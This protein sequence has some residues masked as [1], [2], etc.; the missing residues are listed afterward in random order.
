M[1]ML[2]NF[3]SAAA[4]LTLSISIASASVVTF[5]VQDASGTNRQMAWMQDGLGYFYGLSGI[6]GINGD[7]QADVNASNQLLVYPA[8]KSNLWAAGMSNNGLVQSG[9]TLLSSQNETGL[10]GL[11]SAGLVYSTV[12]GTSG[13][14]NNASGASGT[15]QAQMGDVVFTAGSTTSAMSAGANIAGWFIKSSDG[16]STFEYTNS[17]ATAPARAPDF[18]IPFNATAELANQQNWSQGVHAVRIPAYPFHV[19]IQNNTGVA[20]PTAISAP[21]NTLRLVSP[22]AAY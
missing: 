13:V 20:L 19:L 11:A 2:R 15:A 3:F 8:I 16:G 5:N 7:Y 6:F 10:S 14:F 4:I 12:S 22:A 9:V 18:V 21:Y 17:G 1:T